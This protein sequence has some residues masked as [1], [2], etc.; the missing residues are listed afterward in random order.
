MTLSW[1]DATAGV[2]VAVAA[3]YLVR[4]AW[5]S[6]AGR[7]TGGCATCCTCPTSEP[8]GHKLVEIAKSSQPASNPQGHPI[9]D[10]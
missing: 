3:A 6:L 2:I 1:Q 7:K 10:A 5:R 4:V 8:D 9:H